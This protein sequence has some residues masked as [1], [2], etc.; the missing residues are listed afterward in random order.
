[1]ARSRKPTKI[2]S[3]MLKRGF[4]QNYKDISGVKVGPPTVDGNGLSITPLYFTVKLNQTVSV[5]TRNIKKYIPNWTTI[6]NTEAKDLFSDRGLVNKCFEYAKKRTR[7]GMG[8]RHWQN[9]T[10]YFT[11]ELTLLTHC[12]LTTYLCSLTRGE[13]I[14]EVVVD[15]ANKGLAYELKFEIYRNLSSKGLAQSRLADALDVTPMKA[16]DLDQKQG[17]G[18]KSTV[19]LGVNLHM[20]AYGWIRDIGRGPTGAGR[21][22]PY[23]NILDWI[24]FYGI[25]PNDPL[26]TQAELAVIICNKIDRDGYKR[27]DFMLESLDTIASRNIAG[28]YVW[29]AVGN[30][31]KEVGKM[32]PK[33]KSMT[34]G[35]QKEVTVPD[36]VFK[37]S[38]N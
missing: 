33:L 16:N 31:D 7:G 17:R 32:V 18:R 23:D 22:T 13:A 10:Q 27:N 8:S 30:L 15:K 38:V 26:M 5:N 12:L 14:S 28:Y 25:T 36:G 1:M 2:T 21:H 6:R 29:T 34:S 20:L 4:R 19:N 9:V 24:R 11:E 37:L 3:A 35:W